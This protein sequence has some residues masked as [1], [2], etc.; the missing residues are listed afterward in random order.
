M[1][2][3]L[4]LIAVLLCGCDLYF[5]GG[6][7]D[8]DVCNGGGTKAE[9]A[10]Q[11]RNPYS[12]QCEYYGGGGYCDESCGPCPLLTPP[13]PDWGM[14]YGACDGLDA[15]TCKATPGC[16]AASLD[17]NTATGRQYWGCWDTAP[18]GPVQG[19][20]LNE[21]AYGCSRHDNCVAVYWSGIDTVETGFAAC[22]PEQAIEPDACDVIDC[23]AGYH[24]EQQCTG[25]ACQPV[26]SA[27]ATC[28]NVDCGANYTC[29]ELCNTGP[30]GILTCG[31]ACVPNQP[32][33]ACAMLQ[34]E[35]ACIAR[36]DCVPVYDGQ[37]CTCYPDH[38][39]CQ[40][41]TYERC[42]GL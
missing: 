17:N 19:S 28:A 12:G 25:D 24:C 1:T 15:L 34:T 6:G 30:N 2:K 29:A 33:P 41:L 4:A 21:D 37:D 31:P 22:E 9:P 36:A 38:C 40:V 42:E 20:C 39:E 10:Y 26:C 32:Q 16:F 23:G 5:G 3:G 18:S 11:L 8:D 27:D 7:G 35:S 14:C 13:E